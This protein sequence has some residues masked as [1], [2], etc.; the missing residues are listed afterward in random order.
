MKTKEYS[1][2]IVAL[3]VVAAGGGASLGLEK[4]KSGAAV[5]VAGRPHPALLAPP[6]RRRD[7]W[8]R[9]HEKA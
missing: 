1:L 6:L 7:A 9:P 3:A 4:V 5:P 8:P 2:S